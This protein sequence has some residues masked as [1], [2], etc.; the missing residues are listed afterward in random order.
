[1]TWNICVAV[2]VEGMM[3]LAEARLSNI[4][5]QKIAEE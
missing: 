1:M 4:E 5:E 3:V 2:G